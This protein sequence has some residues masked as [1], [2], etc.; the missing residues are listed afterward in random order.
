MDL[1]GQIFSCWAVRV[2]TVGV[3][4]EYNLSERQQLC[5]LVH[6]TWKDS[7][8][9]AER[10]GCRRWVLVA[11]RIWVS[12]SNSLSLCC[13]FGRIIIQLLTMQGMCLCLCCV[14]HEH[15]QTHVYTHTH[16]CISKRHTH[17]ITRTHML[18]HACTH[19]RTQARAR[20]W[21]RPPTSL[22]RLRAKKVT[23]SRSLRWLWRETTS[24]CVCLCLCV[25]MCLCVCV[26]VY[27]CVCVCVR[28]T[29]T[30]T[31]T[32]THRERE[33]CVFWTSGS[34]QPCCSLPWFWACFLNRKHDFK[35]GTAK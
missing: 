24:R 21:W 15:T 23:S 17:T 25:C 30:H 12:D 19:A 4:S 16:K 32:H 29:H 3:S 14:C 34:M 11:D 28:D 33:R 18:T 22:E 26:C 2:Q 5:N 20:R 35:T 7:Y 1:E 27:V 10:C 6:R 8:L 13:G 31:H 9:A